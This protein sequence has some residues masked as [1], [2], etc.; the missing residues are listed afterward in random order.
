MQRNCLALGHT[1]GEV[2]RKADQGDGLLGVHGGGNL[3]GGIQVQDA[4]EGFGPGQALDEFLGDVPAVFVQHGQGVVFDFQGGGQ[5]EEK[6]LHDYRRDDQLA[7]LG[8]GQ[9][10]LQLLADES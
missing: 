3:V 10:D 1:P 5:G 8:I 7:A 4:G 6:S 9:K 2:L